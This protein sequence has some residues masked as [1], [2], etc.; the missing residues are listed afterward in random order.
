VTGVIVLILL[1]GL[2]VLAVLW[3]GSLIAQG[4]LYNV[5]TEGLAWRAPAGAAAVTLFAALWCLIHA[6]TDGRYDTLFSFDASDQKTYDELVSISQAPG[7]AETRTPFKRFRSGRGQVEYRDANGRRWERSSSA[8]QVVAVEVEDNGRK[9]R[10]DAQRNP[11]GTFKV[12]PGEYLKFVDPASGRS[13]TDGD[14]GTVR[15]RR[16]GVMI[17]NVVLNLLHLAL[18]FAVFW[19][20]LRYSWSHAV[21]LAVICWLV[22]TVGVLPMMFDQTRK[23]RAAS[24]APPPAAAPAEEG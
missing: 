11:D 4:Y 9:V 6:R 17:G 23:A 8:G 5:P 18:W 14:M 19:P 21:V 7:G 10:F 22:M 1:V 13:M 3:T 24:L 12:A 2:G 20:I 16:T 15:R